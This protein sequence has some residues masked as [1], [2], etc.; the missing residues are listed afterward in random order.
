[1]S[2]VFGTEPEVVRPLSRWGALW[3]LVYRNYVTYRREW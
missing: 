3:L 2:A 1:M